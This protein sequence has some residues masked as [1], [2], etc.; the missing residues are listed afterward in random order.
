MTRPALQERPDGCA[1]VGTRRTVTGDARAPATRGSSIAEVHRPVP[2]ASPTR[3]SGIPRTRPVTARTGRQGVVRRAA[4]QAA[5]E[6]TSDPSSRGVQRPTHQARIVPPMPS[7]TRTAFR[8]LPQ[9]WASRD[10][11]RLVNR[12]AD[13]SLR[14]RQSRPLRR[15][16]P[17]D[18]TLISYRGSGVRCCSSP[19]ALEHSR[20]SG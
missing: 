17:W 5:G 9:K 19:R 7:E 1:A 20:G 10:V 14:C 15:N 16:S 18:T 4:Y 3:R 6:T 8:W 12:L 13:R 2:R 11:T